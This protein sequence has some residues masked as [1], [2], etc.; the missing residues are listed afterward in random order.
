MNVSMDRSRD[1][2]QRLTDLERVV[3]TLCY[4]IQDLTEVLTKEKGFW[5]KTRESLRD[6]RKDLEH[7]Q[8]DMP[9]R[10]QR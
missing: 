3:D 5:P 10:G 8:I 2:E 4:L 1:T 6:V 7:I 9:L